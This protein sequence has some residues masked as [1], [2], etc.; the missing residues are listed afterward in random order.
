MVRRGVTIKEIADVLGHRSIDST[1]I[2]SKVDLPALT[3][4]A[5]P[6]PEVQ[7]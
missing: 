6:W 3:A 1:A 2:Y 4:V 7:P 5:M